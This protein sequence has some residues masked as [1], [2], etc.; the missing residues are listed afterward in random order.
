M[1]IVS[2]GSLESISR[3][4]ST[5]K[6]SSSR[7]S[8]R[9]A[10]SSVQ[11]S[12]DILPPEEP[13]LSWSTNFQVEEDVVVTDITEDVSSDNEQ[14]L[15]L[16]DET[17]LQAKF[18]QTSN[19]TTNSLSVLD[20]AS[21]SDKI[22]QQIINSD[23]V[24]EALLSNENTLK[25]KTKQHENSIGSVTELQDENLEQ[26]ESESSSTTGSYENEGLDPKIRKGM[27]RIKKLDNIL[28]EKVKREKEVKK[29]RRDQERMW[30][31][32]LDMLEKSRDAELGKPVDLGPAHMLALGAPNE[33]EDS[34][35]EDSPPVTPL[36]ATQP[37]VDEERILR[38]K[39][40]EETYFEIHGHSGDTE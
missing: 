38:Q 37:L 36:F 6:R 27:E 17:S 19:K 24:K 16:T 13:S 8:V 7:S 26:A 20:E 39:R 4:A 35:S 40:H 18:E 21:L 28:T 22:G 1:E 25:E 15:L 3:P 11:H 32:H 12:L 30:R 5:S 2:E 10:S 29:Q 34:V 33:T 14:D 23:S 31:D 9:S